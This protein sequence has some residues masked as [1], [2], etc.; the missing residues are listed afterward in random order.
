MELRSKYPRGSRLIFSHCLLEH[1]I[2]LPKCLGYG[3]MPVHN[4]EKLVVGDYH[5]SVHMCKAPKLLQI[6]EKLTKGLGAG[7]KPEVGENA[8]EES[9]EEISSALKGADMVFV[10]CGMGGGTASCR[11]TFPDTLRI[12]SVIPVRVVSSSGLSTAIFTPVCS[13]S[14]I[15]SL[16]PIFRNRC[17][18]AVRFRRSL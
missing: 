7:A 13:L 15:P 16:S 5:Q 4:L 18:S 8:A 11:D 12:T 2:R 10:T 1:L 9:A 6:G 3:S 17:P 14:R